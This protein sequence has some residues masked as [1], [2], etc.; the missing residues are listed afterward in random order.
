MTLRC[1]LPA[2]I[3]WFLLSASL[4][5]QSTIDWEV[6]GGGTEV[7]A[8]GAYTVQGTVGQ[9]FTT[10]AEGGDYTLAAG[11][12]TYIVVVATPGAPMLRVTWDESSA[13]MRIS[14]P[15]TATGWVLQ[16]A[17]VLAGANTQWVRLE[18]PYETTDTEQQWLVTP[19][20]GQQFYRLQRA[21]SP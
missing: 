21:P 5:A 13:R 2:A 7:S 18:G 6:M 20:P 10:G 17:D 16:S 8:G 9:P 4:S 11:F 19:S 1:I 14:W 12:W 15:I 3:S